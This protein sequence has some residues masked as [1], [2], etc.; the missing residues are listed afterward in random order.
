MKIQ[1]FQE[2]YFQRIIF[3]NITF[4][5]GVKT[6]ITDGFREYTLII[7]DLGFNH[8]RCTFHDM[9]NLM[10]KLIKKHNGIN[11]RIKKLNTDIKELEKE[12]KEICKKGRTRK[13]VI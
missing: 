1:L 11:R 2:N 9:K 10:N 5:L 4:N 8:Q 6:I 3:R 13:N 12:I 7:D